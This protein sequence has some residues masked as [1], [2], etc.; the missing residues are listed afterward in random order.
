MSRRSPVLIAATVALL[1][2]CASQ[3]SFPSLAPRPIER[4]YGSLPPPTGP[5]AKAE[6]PDCEPIAKAE[7]VPTPDDPALRS[8][9]IELNAQAQK[10]QQSFE[11]SL[12]KTTQIVDHAG[13][14]GSDNWIAAQ[15]ALS[16][17]EASRNETLT[18]S[19]A[20]DALALERAGA[21]T[22]EAD[23]KAVTDAAAE[24]RRL[25]EAQDVQLHPLQAK[26]TP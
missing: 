24:A 9:L 5:C 4:Q 22:S 20:L 10:G 19:S 21:P 11:A 16:Q 23:L 26:L 15:Q 14:M 7:P 6:T 12:A 18:A 17:L 25:A 2:G 3:G 1:G 13:A 8:R